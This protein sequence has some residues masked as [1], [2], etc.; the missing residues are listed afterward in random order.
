MLRSQFNFAD[1]ETSQ[2]MGPR[3]GLLYFVCLP[4]LPHPWSAS[5]LFW[6]KQFGKD[7]TS[8]LGCSRATL[9]GLQ[10]GSGKYAVIAVPEDRA[11]LLTS[12]GNWGKLQPGQHLKLG[13]YTVEYYSAIKKNKI[14]SFAATWMEHFIL[15]YI[16]YFQ[17]ILGEVKRRKTNTIWYHLYLESNIWHNGTFPKQR[18]LNDF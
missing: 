7:C 8:S 3:V 16:L 5:N 11:G 6:E 13:I 15:K 4:V 1:S 10:P 18:K 9:P 17:T 12:A 14:I 2:L